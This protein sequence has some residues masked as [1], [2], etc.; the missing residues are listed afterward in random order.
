MNRLKLTTQVML[1]LLALVALLLGTNL[2]SIVRSMHEQQLSAQLAEMAERNAMSDELELGLEMQSAGVRAYILSASDSLLQRDREGQKKFNDSLH[3]LK[4]H[5][6]NPEAL[7]TEEQIEKAYAQYRKCLDQEIEFTR[8]GHSDQAKAVLVSP[9]TTGW[10]TKLRELVAHLNQLESNL[11]DQAADNLLNSQKSSIHKNQFTMLLS[12]VIA[13]LLLRWTMHSIERKTAGLVHA[14]DELSA[15]NLNFSD[16]FI[17]SEDALGKASCKMNRMKESLRALVETIQ[18]HAAMID[19]ASEK[20]A[21]TATNQA[22]NATQQRQQG[23]QVAAAMQQMTAAIHEV[24]E[25]GS[26]MA[27]VSQDASGTADA[28]V[29]KARTALSSMQILSD[30][31]QHTSTRVD[32][33]GQSS[34]RIS[35]ITR[36]IEEIASQTNLLA[37]NASI[38]AARAGVHG[39]GFAVVAGEVRRLAERTA[40]ATKEINDMVQGIQQETSEA[41]DA[42]HHGKSQVEA[43]VSSTEEIGESLTKILHTVSQVDGMVAQI[44]AAATEQA[45]ATDE[46][47]QSIQR[48]SLLV[49]Q[50]AEEASQADRAC[51]QLRELSLDLH[52]SVAVFNL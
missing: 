31:V 10:R 2:F 13:V 33:L 50:S 43:S 18:H 16:L 8:Q 34:E 39:Q 26:R 28:S 35:Q 42:M 20:I 14:I 9:E 44:A 1:G 47:N 37:L 3:S 21:S 23:L 22:R 46:V 11:R 19:Q 27:I 52:R 24:A 4:T 30:A 38:E 49:D 5:I 25:N 36:V 45:S 32:A 6:K 41:I 12:T 48:I 29:L 51:G 15:G 17:D 40:D 7:Q